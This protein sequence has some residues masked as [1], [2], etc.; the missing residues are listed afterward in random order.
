MK[1]WWDGLIPPL[2][3]IVAAAVLWTIYCIFFL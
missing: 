1:E 2:K 3:I